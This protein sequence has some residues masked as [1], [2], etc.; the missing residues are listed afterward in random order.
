MFWIRI[1]WTYYQLVRHFLVFYTL[2]FCLNFRP[3]F[4]NKANFWAALKWKV[5]IKYCLI[6]QLP[7]HIN[8]K[9][10]I[11]IFYVHLVSFK[12]LIVKEE[13]YNNCSFQSSCKCLI[14]GFAVFYHFIKFSQELFK[15]VLTLLN[16]SHCLISFL[17]SALKG[18][19]KSKNVYEK[20]QFSLNNRFIWNFY[21]LWCISL[22]W[23]LTRICLHNCRRQFGKK[24]MYIY[25]YQIS[26]RVGFHSDWPGDDYPKKEQWIN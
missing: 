11:F 4:L 8:W 25:Q 5:L 23:K 15:I 12:I 17:F 7:S 22:P 21:I 9:S 18:L 26:F 14:C 10:L 16:T 2:E 24:E 19:F 13:S 20:H 1:E 6:L 3:Y